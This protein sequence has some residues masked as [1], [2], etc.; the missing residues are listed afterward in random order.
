MLKMKEVCMT[1][2]LKKRIISELNNFPENKINTLMDFIIFLKF[3]ENIK[4]PN[5]VTEQT[6]KDTDAGKNLNSYDCLDDFFAK[7]DS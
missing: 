2:T 4:I 7:M 5:E 6:F 3:E 1:A